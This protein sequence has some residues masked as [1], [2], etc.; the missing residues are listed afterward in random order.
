MLLTDFGTEVMLMTLLCETV[1]AFESILVTDVED[2][3]VFA[4]LI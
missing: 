4:D 3:T 1:D 2:E